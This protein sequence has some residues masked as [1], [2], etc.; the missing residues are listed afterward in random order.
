MPYDAIFESFNKSVNVIYNASQINLI[1]V[2]NVFLFSLPYLLFSFLWKALWVIIILL[3]EEDWATY[4]WD[5][6]KN[7]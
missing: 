7:S 5:L 4:I 3:L 6:M 2:Q 1:K